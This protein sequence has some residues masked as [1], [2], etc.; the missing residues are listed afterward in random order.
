[1]NGVHDTRVAEN[2]PAYWN[3]AR[4]A[5]VVLVYLM[6]LGV[7]PIAHAYL[8]VTGAITEPDTL[9]DFAC[10]SCHA[11][12]R[13]HISPPDRSCL[14]CHPMDFD[15][16]LAT[17]QAQLHLER[18]GLAFGIIIGAY[19]AFCLGALMFVLRPVSL[20]RILFVICAGLLLGGS[21]AA[22]FGKL[23]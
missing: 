15:R 3:R 10:L 1:M 11:A 17:A 14:S 16:H 13:G 5:L 20:P 22:V 2:T 6:A 12:N 7:A 23:A 4:V 18:I 8:S 19:A 9:D 21:I